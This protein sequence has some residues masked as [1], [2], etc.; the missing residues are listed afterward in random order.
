MAPGLTDEQIAQLRDEVSAGKSPRVR[1][2]GAQFESG[3]VRAVGDPAADGSDYVTVRVKVDGV[4]DDLR[5]SPRELSRGKSAPA[6]RPARKAP[7]PARTD[8]ASVG[9]REATPAARA[10]ADPAPG[11]RPAT[12]RRRAATS[13]AAPAPAAP[14][15]A[16]RRPVAATT[17]P[18]RGGRKAASGASVTITLT[19]AGTSWT[20]SAQRGAKSV[21]KNVGVNPGV[22]SAVA[23]LLQVSAL[24]D[25]VAA[26]NDTARVEAEVRAEELRAELARIQA[27]LDSHRL[28]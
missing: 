23:G 10:S 12:P 7:A 14:A 16:S 20:V 6:E 22:V 19:S 15:T 17:A 28:P 1:I 13:S 3:A 18:K 21:V 9:R 5:F 8:A 2:A 4:T 25:A 26:V 11:T 24:E 27:V